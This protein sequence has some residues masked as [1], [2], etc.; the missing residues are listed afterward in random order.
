MKQEDE[1]FGILNKAVMPDEIEWRVQSQTKDKTKLIIVPYINN[2]CVMERF[3][4]AFGNANWNSSFL[5]VTDGFLCTITA[6]VGDKTVSRTDGANK[7][8]IEALKGGISDS[9]KRTAVQFGVGRC[10][11]KYPKVMVETQDKYIPNWVYS[12]LDKMVTVI[13]NGGFDR[14][15]VILKE[16]Q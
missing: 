9:M 11:Y 10:L 15:F 13:N 1:V 5:E 6:T 2:R 12:R 14:N 8:S 3:D 4:F 16:D 7:T